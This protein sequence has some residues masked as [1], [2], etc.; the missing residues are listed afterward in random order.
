MNKD[1]IKI[2]GEVKNEILEINPPEFIAFNY[3]P[4][5][6]QLSLLNQFLSERFKDLDLLN[7]KVDF[8]GKE[9]AVETYSDTDLDFYIS[10]FALDKMFI[11]CTNM[12]TKNLEAL[13]FLIGER[14]QW[15]GKKFSIVHDA[16]TSDLDSTNVSVRFQRDA[17]EKL[18]D[19]LDEIPYDYVLVGWYHSHP[20]FSSFMSHVDVDTQMRIFN[21]PFHAAIVID[22]LSLELKSFR[23]RQEKCIEIPYAVFI[24]SKED[25]F[26]IPVKTIQVKCDNCNEIFNVRED[27]QDIFKCP[28]CKNLKNNEKSLF[29]F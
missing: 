14:R 9:S 20:G 6:T 29:G 26:K 2:S 24:E 12:A 11:H 7:I 4:Y 15:R 5:K 27:Q 21:K 23:M 3:I 13:G 28:N 18:F 16:I 8:E 22:P 10:D 25:E 17:F 1:M 19:S